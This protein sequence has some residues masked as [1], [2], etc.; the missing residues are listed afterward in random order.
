MRW[1]ATGQAVH[2]LRAFLAKAQSQKAHFD[3]R[4]A[5]GSLKIYPLNVGGA[6]QGP[7]APS[8]PPPVAA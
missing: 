2:N 1:L 4:E 6:G 5:D 7:P 3:L 8:L